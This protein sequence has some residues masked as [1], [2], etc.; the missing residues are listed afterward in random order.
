MTRAV[1]R[2]RSSAAVTSTG[3]GVRGSFHASGVSTRGPVDAVLG[4][5][6]TLIPVVCPSDSRK[7]GPRSH[8]LNGF[9]TKVLARGSKCRRVGTMNFSRNLYDSQV[10]S[11][12]DL[13]ETCVLSSPT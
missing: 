7:I 2:P 13:Q 4:L 3:V 12:I 1:N 10:V 6:A 11:T 5:V 8:A 9:G